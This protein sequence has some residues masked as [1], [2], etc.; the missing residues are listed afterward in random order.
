MHF[1][2]FI[3]SNWGITVIGAAGVMDVLFGDSERFPHP[4]RLAGTIIETGERLCRRIPVNPIFQGAVLTLSM[5]L[6]TCAAV[7]MVLGLLNSAAAYAAW[8]FSVITIYFS[9]SLKCLADEAMA[10]KHALDEHGI[11]A[12]RQ[13]VSRLVGRETST[14][15]EHGIAMATIETVAENL[16]D[17]LVAPLFYACIGGPA[18]CASYRVVNTLDAM[19]GYRNSKYLEFGRVAA[20]LDDLANWIPARLSVVSVCAA[21]RLTGIGTRGDI[22]RVVRRDCR[23]HSSPNSGFPESAF[24]AALG[25]RIGG[26]ATYHGQI[27]D[28]PWIN[29]ECAKPVPADIERAIKLLYAAAGVVYA[30]VIVCGAGLLFLR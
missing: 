30:F 8:I 11:E 2:I 25:V 16:V 10:V 13:Q 17:G 14:L 6:I 26:P 9:I 12:A 29:A 23:C 7:T 5:V 19:I 18:L 22:R 28:Y 20:R 24:A 15:D 21:S 1:H 3:A 4:V 27:T